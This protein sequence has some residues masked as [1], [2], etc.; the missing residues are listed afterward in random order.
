[1]AERKIFE[2]KNEDGSTTETKV[3]EVHA[4][5]M[6]EI[7]RFGDNVKEAVESI[8]DEVVSVREAQNRYEKNA[9]GLVEAKIAK[10]AES[11][12]TKVE[13]VD[14]LVAKQDKRMDELD[15]LFQKRSLGADEKASEEKRVKQAIQFKTEVL[16]LRN[17]MLQAEILENGVQLKDGDLQDFDLY[18][19]E[20]NKLLRVNEGQ[21][22]K[23]YLSVG[24][25]PDGGL[26]VPPQ[27]SGQIV[28]RIWEQDPVRQLAAVETISSD[29]LEMMEDVDQADAGWETEIIATNETRTPQFNKKRIPAHIQSARPRASQKLLDDASI[30]VEAWLAQKVAERFGRLEG[31]AFVTG[32]GVDRPRGFLTYSMYQDS[33]TLNLYRFGQIEYI[34]T[35]S[36][37]SWGSTADFIY[38]M[39]YA[40]LDQY[41][42]RAT[43]LMNRLTMLKM[44]LMKDTTGR[45]LWQPLISASLQAGP[46]S[47]LAGLPCRMSASMP[48]Q[49]ANAYTIA[50]ADWKR[51]YLIVDRLG[52]TI[53]R[54]PYT[55]KPFVEFYTRRRVGGD[56][57]NFQAIKVL[58]MA[59][60]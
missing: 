10:L 47:V 33:T 39:V 43:F 23:K 48:S 21:L 56:V 18:C 50:L 8:R 53:Q 27:L 12:T 20:F 51:A 31:T 6:A 19:K 52:V 24:S 15:V 32:N 2:T 30:N 26:V 7:K 34:P 29:A 60:S 55:A 4:A 9:D 38:K 1:M 22:D 37:G 44:M 28:E 54:D 25:D 35:E 16:S 3:P 59:D 46:V 36:A 41:Q 45:W 5:A 13:E 40:L 58:K 17:H 57:V 14:K 49:A 42:A 11:I